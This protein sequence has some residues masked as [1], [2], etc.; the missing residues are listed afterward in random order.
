M[1]AAITYK[2]IINN[3][4]KGYND[5]QDKLHELG[6]TY[7]TS[8]GAVNNIGASVT[9]G[10]N[11]PLSVV[12][13]LSAD[14]FTNATLTAEKVSLSNPSVA[15]THTGGTAVLSSSTTA[16]TVVIGRNITNGSGTFRAKATKSGYIKSGTKSSNIDLGAITPTVTGN[17]TVYIQAGAYTVSGSVTGTPT[18]TASVSGTGTTMTGILTTKPSTGTDGTNYW[19]F[20]PSIGGNNGKVTSTAKITTGS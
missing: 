18:A 4:I 14:A 13:I 7:T 8:A 5:I 17:G 1:M 19:T 9:S 6:A 12:N 20:A 11:T 3:A 2:T 10:K 15:I 16:Y